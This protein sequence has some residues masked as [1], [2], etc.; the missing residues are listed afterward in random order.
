MTNEN[1]PVKKFLAG[2]VSAALWKNNTKFGDGKEVETLSV[3]LDRRYKD[4]DGT[5]KSSG[6]LKLND[7]PKAVLVL[8]KAY[9]YMASKGEDN[10]AIP[11]EE[12][13][14]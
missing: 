1:K 4:K 13:V 9:D 10:E 5:W 2:G 6:S 12:V 3:T 8:S 7:I 14:V 11:E